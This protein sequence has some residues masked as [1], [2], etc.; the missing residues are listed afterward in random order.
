[1]K[2]PHCKKASSSF[3]NAKRIGCS[4]CAPLLLVFLTRVL[5]TPAVALSIPFVAAFFLYFHQ[6]LQARGS[7]TRTICCN[8]KLLLGSEPS[9]HNQPLDWTLFRFGKNPQV[10]SYLG[11]YSFSK[12]ASGGTRL[13]VHFPSSLVEHKISSFFNGIEIIDLSKK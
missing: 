5:H 8:S 7:S 12:V 6:V 4:R 9:Q 1:V 11:L 3:S 10:S 2:C 13:Q